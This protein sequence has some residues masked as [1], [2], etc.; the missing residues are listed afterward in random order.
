VAKIFK[1]VLFLFLL[2]VIGL[3]IYVKFF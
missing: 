2:A 1:V 3:F